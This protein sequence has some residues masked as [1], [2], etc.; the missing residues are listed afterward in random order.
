MALEVRAYRP[1]DETAWSAYIQAHR[2]SVFFHD[3]KWQKVVSAAYGHEPHYQCAWED[4]ELVGVLPLSLLRKVLLKGNVLVSVPCGDYAGVLASSPEAAQAL[5]QRAREL[6][7]ELRAQY[8]ELRQLNSPLPDLPYR[9]SR[10]A[11]I[12]EFESDPQAQ[13]KRLPRSMRRDF[14]RA[15]EA[16]YV[17]E[18]R[19]GDAVGEFHPLYARV[20]HA[21]GLPFHS[22]RFFELLFS[23]FPDSALLLVRNDGQL[24]GAAVM[25]FFRDTMELGWIATEA[26]AMRQ[27]A[28][29][30]LLWEG[31]QFGMR[32]GASR[33]SFG[34][35]PVDSGQEHF[36]KL[37]GA[38]AH[39]LKYHYVEGLSDSFPLDEEPRDSKSHRLFRSVWR[40]L[41]ASVARPLGPKVLQ[42]LVW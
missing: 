20:C 36:K 4:G 25:A 11:M 42:R 3:V 13:E 32:R 35:S 27:S 23:E 30:L 7:Q 2:H 26:E 6:C 39:D 34:R 40:R 38:E 9:A 1:E 22:Q 29:K 14:R 28:N 5:V 18:A 31:V 41:P 12:M 21:M 10:V 15:K 16:G 19:G 8:A 17:F 24:A 37:W 33:M